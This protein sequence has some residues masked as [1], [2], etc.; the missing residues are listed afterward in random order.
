MPGAQLA[1]APTAGLERM[2]DSALVG[3][4]GT[5]SDFENMSDRALVVLALNAARDERTAIASLEC[6]NPMDSAP[7]STPDTIMASG[8]RGL[9]DVMP[10]SEAAL[11]LELTQ[12]AERAEAFEET[13]KTLVASGNPVAVEDPE[14]SQAI[15]RAQINMGKLLPAT[16]GTTDPLVQSLRAAAIERRFGVGRPLFLLLI[17]LFSVLLSP[18]VREAYTTERAVQLLALLSIVLLNVAFAIFF[19]HDAD[20]IVIQR[21]FGWVLAVLVFPTCLLDYWTSICV[22]ASNPAPVRGA[23]WLRAVCETAVLARQIVY[24]SCGVPCSTWRMCRQTQVATMLIYLV[25]C[26]ILWISGASPYPGIASSFADACIFSG[27]WIG[28]V[29]MLTT[30]RRVYLSALIN[31]HTLNVP[32]EQFKRLPPSGRTPLVAVSEL[33]EGCAPY[34]PSSFC[35]LAASALDT[36]NAAAASW[37]DRPIVIGTRLDCAYGAGAHRPPASVSSCV[38]SAEGELAVLSSHMGAR[39]AV[40]RGAD[41]TLPSYPML[42]PFYNESLQSVTEDGEGVVYCDPAESWRL[43]LRVD[44]NGLLVDGAGSPLAPEGEVRGM[45]VMAGDRDILVHFAGGSSAEATSDEWAVVEANGHPTARSP[46]S[47][48]RHS[49]LMAGHAVAAAGMMIINRGRLLCV[50]NESGHYAPPPS[51]LRAVIER[52]A[53]MGVAGL[54]NVRLDIVKCSADGTSQFIIGGSIHSSSMTSQASV[55]SG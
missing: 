29:V 21:P 10:E 11:R 25:C 42:A 19:P 32:L 39:R 50:S 23:V 53:E 33:Q 31:M 15:N 34:T 30:E 9:H 6:N 17:S 48:W 46:T 13:I 26:C 40:T 1:R 47:A 2:S 4:P 49:S 43:R 5:Q 44:A 45:F 37:F 8:F 41:P 20:A 54:E 3:L 28:T 52:L 14:I 51:S 18:A 16:T 55:A 12:R 7:D 35:M 38:S 24:F 36:L 22:T 27:T